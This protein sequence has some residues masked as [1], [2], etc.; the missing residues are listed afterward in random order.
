MPFSTPVLNFD[1]PKLLTP[2]VS[3]TFNALHEKGLKN[4][5]AEYIYRCICYSKKIKD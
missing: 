1:G 3:R 5:C 4:L 2:R